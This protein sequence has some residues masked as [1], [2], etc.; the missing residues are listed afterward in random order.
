MVTWKLGNLHGELV[1]LGKMIVIQS[2]TNTGWFCFTPYEKLGG[3][4]K[5]LKKELF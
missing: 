2:V 1:S 3:K 5:E 4:R